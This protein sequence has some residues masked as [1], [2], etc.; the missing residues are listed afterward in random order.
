[1]F[2]SWRDLYRWQLWTE[3]VARPDV[4]GRGPLDLARLQSVSP[5]G[6][7]ESAVSCGRL[8]C[9]Q[10][11]KP[12]QPLGKWRHGGIRH[13]RTNHLGQRYATAA[14]R[15]AFHFLKHSVDFWN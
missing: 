5:Q 4:Q 12:E 3:H 10:H 6:G 9:I 11:R 7:N 8:Q 2:G 14:A 13:I 15:I 1:M